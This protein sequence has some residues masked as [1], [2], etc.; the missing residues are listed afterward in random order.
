MFDNSLDKTFKLNVVFLR[1]VLLIQTSTS[2]V[3]QVV[4]T[5]AEI[6]EEEKVH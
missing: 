5:R 4:Y 3:A 2:K 6:D 1:S